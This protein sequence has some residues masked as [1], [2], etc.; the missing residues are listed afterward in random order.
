[1]DPGKRADL[2]GAALARRSEIGEQSFAARATRLAKSGP[3]IAT[4]SSWLPREPEKTER[5]HEGRHTGRRHGHP[6]QRGDTSAAK[7]YDRDWRQ[8]C[9]VAHHEDLFSLQL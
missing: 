8:A 2:V 5:T 4:S 1:M 3:R 9:P 7:A 6:D